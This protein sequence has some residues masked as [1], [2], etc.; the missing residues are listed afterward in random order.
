M[1]NTTFAVCHC[2]VVELVSRVGDTPLTHPVAMHIVSEKK[3]LVWCAATRSNVEIAVSRVRPPV[4]T[5]HCTHRTDHD[6]DLDNLD[7]LDPIF[8]VTIFTCCARA[9]LQYSASYTSHLAN[10][11]HVR[12]SRAI[13]IPPGKR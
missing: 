7:N 3:C 1:L 6:L 2:L 12:K 10:M 5:K 11:T 9:V 8:V 13:Q 4:E